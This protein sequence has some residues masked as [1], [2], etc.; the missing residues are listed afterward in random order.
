MTY[1]CACNVHQPKLIITVQ[2]AIPVCVCSHTRTA[3]PLLL[4]CRYGCIQGQTWSELAKVY[5]YNSSNLRLYI[6]NCQ[7]KVSKAELDGCVL[8]DGWLHVELQG[9]DS[10]VPRPHPLARRARG[11]HETRRALRTSEMGTEITV[12]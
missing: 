1:L 8:C 6:V 11:G 5:I 7:N 2:I 9:G 12:P 3:Y 10:L 4:Y